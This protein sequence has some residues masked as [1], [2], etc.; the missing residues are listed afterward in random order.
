M[1]PDDSFWLPPV[2]S[3]KFV[4]ALFLFGKGDVIMDHLVLEKGLYV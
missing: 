2:L 4:E 3:G 1:W